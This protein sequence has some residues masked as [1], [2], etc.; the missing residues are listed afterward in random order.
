M[1]FLGYRKEKGLN[2]PVLV[3][4]TDITTE[5]NLFSIEYETNPLHTDLDQRLQLHTN[6]LR[7]VYDSETVL[8]L[9]THFM[10]P[11]KIN[12]SELEGA[13]TLKISNF[14]ERSATGMQYMLDKH[15][16]VEID[17]NCKPNIVIIPYCG[18]YNAYDNIIVISLGTLEVLTK[19]RKYRQDMVNRMYEKGEEHDRILETIM[20]SAYDMYNITIA[21]LQV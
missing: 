10:P 4:S 7:I 8:Q 15:A 3:Q 12:L 6:S 16:K 18:D 20:N 5:E 17:I 19:T 11:K 2:K 14:K 1:K 9:Y 21:D 13:A